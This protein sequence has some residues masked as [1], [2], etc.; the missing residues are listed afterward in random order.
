MSPLHLLLLLIQKERST[1]MA[2]NIISKFQEQ[3]KQTPCNTALTDGKRRMTYTELDQVSDSY[4]N[5][6]MQQNNISA[7]GYIAV[8]MSHS[9]DCIVAILAVLKTGNGYIPIEPSF[10]VERISYMLQES[11][12]TTVIT[13]TNFLT[14]FRNNICSYCFDEITLQQPSTSLNQLPCISSFDTAYV[15]YTSG[16][17]GTPKG[18]MVSHGNVVNYVKAFQTEFRIT[19]EDCVLQNS[20][21]TFDIFVDEVFPILLAGGTLAIPEETTKSDMS[22]LISFIEKNHVTVISAFPYFIAELNKF[23]IPNSIRL[24]ISGGDVLRPNYISNL[25]NKVEIYNTY[26]PTE[27]TVCATYYRYQEK[28]MEKYSSIPIGKPINGVE[29]YLL[30]SNKNPVATGE[31]GEI[32]IRGAGVSKGYLKKPE[33][34][35]KYFIPN[36]FMEND[37]L[38]CS[39]DLGIMEQ[40]GTILFLRRKDSQVMIEGKRVEPME[41]EQCISNYDGVEFVSVQAT[42]DQEDNFYLTSYITSKKRIDR[43]NLLRYMKLYL[44]DFMIPKYF[45]ILTHI[46]LTINGK[47]N[48]KELP[49]ILS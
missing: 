21:C 3:V 25:Q 41:V 35:K 13:E 28:D 42:T 10:P 14:Q 19:G 36:P 24:L 29:I 39:G 5:F 6:L 40:D 1:H 43:D 9:I 16:S 34:T 33:E 32:C 46:P 20:V 31:I 23:K 48:I 49:Q 37:T 8:C 22:K 27:T 18:V 11:E 38:Y 2:N 4:A 30:D 7:N 47:V 44:P 15:L 17:T 26:G 45:V 12:T